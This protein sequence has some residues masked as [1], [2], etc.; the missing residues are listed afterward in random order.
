MLSGD[1]QRKYILRPD[2]VAAVVPVVGTLETGLVTSKRK[3]AGLPSLHSQK[4]QCY[5]DCCSPTSYS[6]L[7]GKESSFITLYLLKFTAT[8]MFC[9]SVQ[10]T[11]VDITFL[12]F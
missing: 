12:N 9:G 6:E 1:A 8:Y 4:T 10:V 2:P 3:P 5:I 7:F 11:L